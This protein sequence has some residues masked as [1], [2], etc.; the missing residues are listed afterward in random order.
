M[1][2]KQSCFA[3]NLRNKHWEDHMSSF[4]GSIGD[5]TQGLALARKM[6]YYLSR[7]TS[8]SFP[9]LLCYITKIILIDFQIPNQSCN[10]EA[11]GRDLFTMCYIFIFIFRFYLL[12]FCYGFFQLCSWRILLIKWFSFHIIFAWFWYPNNTSLNQLGNIL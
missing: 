2:N 10:N 9:P 5:W 1:L 4:S 7:S 12:I 11:H 8:P 3:P 6:I